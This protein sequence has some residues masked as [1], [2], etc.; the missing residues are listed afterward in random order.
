MIRLLKEGFVVRIS[1][2]RINFATD[3]SKNDANTLKHSVEFYKSIPCIKKI[4]ST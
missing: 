1:L 2:N 3:Y 4:D